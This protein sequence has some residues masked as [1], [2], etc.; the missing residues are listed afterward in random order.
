MIQVKVNKSI[1]KLAVTGDMAT[2]AAESGVMIR[3]IYTALPKEDAEEFRRV[4]TKFVA[5][6]DS[7]LFRKRNHGRD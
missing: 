2:L 7:P 5:A 6:T 3:K 1:S 4:F